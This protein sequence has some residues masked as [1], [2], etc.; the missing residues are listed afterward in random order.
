VRFGGRTLLLVGGRRQATAIADP[1]GMTTKGQA[2]ATVTADPCGMTTK[3]QATATVT[4]DPL[5]DDENKRAG[6]G[7]RESSYRECL[8]CRK[9]RMMLLFLYA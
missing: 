6:N 8:S 4:A 3:G 1:C 2:T 5:R 7:S 9:D